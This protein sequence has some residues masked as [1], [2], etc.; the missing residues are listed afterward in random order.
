ML[1]NQPNDFPIGTPL[2]IDDDGNYAPATSDSTKPIVG[3]VGNFNQSYPVTGILG[4][5]ATNGLPAGGTEGQILIKNSSTNYSAGWTSLNLGSVTGVGTNGA[6]GLQGETG[7]QGSMGGRGETGAQGVTGVGYPGPRGE[8]GP[9]GIG[10]TGLMGP[11]GLIGEQGY[12]GD[13]G[14]TGLQGLMGIRGLTG[15]Q[16]VQ[17]QTG[18]QGITG[19]EGLV[20][21]TGMLGAQGHTGQDG[22]QGQT[23]I[24][25]CTGPEGVQGNPGD[26]GVS[27]AQ[28]TTGVRGFTGLM[29][30]TGAGFSGILYE[31]ISGH[32][33]TPSVK[34]YFLDLYTKYAYSIVDITARTTSGSC[35]ISLR[36]NGTNITN[37]TSLSIS[38]TASTTSVGYSAAAGRSI[39][40]YVDST[41]SAV[42]LLFTIKIGRTV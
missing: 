14:H 26:R 1:I 27:G 40:L 39:S 25:G 3:I 37:A 32:I 29:G 22:S 36:D 5:T 30:V 31:E 18:V 19:Q 28:G 24:Q 42:D 23:G 12:R 33:E 20:G 41:S 11:T 7:I 10:A 34:Y 16:G 38:S 17:G 15:I 6:T 2:I 9:F 21:P 4:L 8:T 35:V 13:Q